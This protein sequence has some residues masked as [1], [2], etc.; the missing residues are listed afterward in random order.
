M[1]IEQLKPMAKARVIDLVSAAG[2]DVSDWSDYDGAAAANPKYCYEWSFVVPDKVV[3]PNLWYEEFSSQGTR[4]W[5]QINMRAM[6]QEFSGVKGHSVWKYRAIRMD[7]ALRL[8]FE[9]HLPVR[10]II[11]S[12]KRRDITKADSPA[13]KVTTRL[14]DSETWAVTS[15]DNKT[16]DCTITRGVVPQQYADQFVVESEPDLQVVQK[17]VTG[18][19]Y[20]R[21]PRVRDNVLLRAQGKCEYCSAPGFAM[22]D[23]RTYLETHH[24]APLCE[25]GPDCTSNVVALCPNHHRE[26]HHGKNAAMLRI[27]L[28]KI[29]ASGQV[30]TADRL[31]LMSE[32]TKDVIE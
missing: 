9:K 5:R 21:D 22:A 17:T 30:S 15:Y 14:L 7:E 26:A 29:A 4:I 28:A 6:A 27:E 11:C 23:G 20:V 25:N 2:V 8:A 1:T 3:V 12:G 10:A 32:S 19:V 18:K 16:G 31:G 13:S 24:V